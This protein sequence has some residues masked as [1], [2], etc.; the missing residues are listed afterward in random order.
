MLGVL[1]IYFFN[2]RV[3]ELDARGMLQRL[4]GMRAKF[5]PEVDAE[6]ALHS[7]ENR[8]RKAEAKRRL[9]AKYNSPKA[10]SLCHVHWSFLFSLPFGKDSWP[11]WF[12]G[13]LGN[14][15]S[16]CQFPGGSPSRAC[17]WVVRK[18]RSAQ[19]WGTFSPTVLGMLVELFVQ[20]LGG[21]VLL[22]EGAHCE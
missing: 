18:K 9:T 4:R 20:G 22:K 12:Q 2:T 19:T 5:V 10:L 6:M 21:V 3:S 8:R 7:Q 16:Y 1:F 11:R 17:L 13:E 14:A 15:S